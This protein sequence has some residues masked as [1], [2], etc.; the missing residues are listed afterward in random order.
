MFKKLFMEGVV[1]GIFMETDDA[2]ME[3][4]I[5]EANRIHRLYNQLD[6]IQVGVM[7]L[8]DLVSALKKALNDDDEPDD[9]ESEEET[10]IIDMEERLAKAINDF[11]HD[12][13][14]EE[15]ENPTEEE[16]HEAE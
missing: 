15:P 1:S 14:P 5:A 7:T 2:D 6:K 16:N 4:M 13:Q 3:K 9:S 12:D 8:D 10:P 11:H